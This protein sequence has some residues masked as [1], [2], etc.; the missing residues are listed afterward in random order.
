M[1]NDYGMYGHLDADKEEAGEALR[2]S[3]RQSSSQV[4]NSAEIDPL[5]TDAGVQERFERSTYVRL[6]AV[7]PNDW[8]AALFWKAINQMCREATGYPMFFQ[9]SEGARDV[10]VLAGA[11]T[12]NFE[13]VSVTMEGPRDA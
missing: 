8:D 7:L 5:L 4:T 1:A 10:N 3:P 13:V 11:N 12:A 2:N 9:T 6:Y